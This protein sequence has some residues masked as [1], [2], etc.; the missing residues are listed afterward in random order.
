MAQ[1]PS[2]SPSKEKGTESHP[3]GEETPMQPVIGAIDNDHEEPAVEYL[4]GM[5]LHGT[6]VAWVFQSQ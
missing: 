1:A 6:T 3:Q 2:P 4:K 5:K